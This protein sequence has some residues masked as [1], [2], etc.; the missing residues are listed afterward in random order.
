MNKKTK[1]IP[2]KAKPKQAAKIP[3]YTLKL[4]FSFDKLADAIRARE[5][6]LEMMMQEFGPSIRSVRKN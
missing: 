1:P 4:N 5:M 3:N 2:R 6:I